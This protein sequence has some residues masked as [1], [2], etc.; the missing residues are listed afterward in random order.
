[1]IQKVLGGLPNQVQMAIAQTGKRCLAPMPYESDLEYL[2]E[3][4]H[5]G[6]NRLRIRKLELE[7]PTRFR[8][9]DGKDP[10][11]L[12]SEYRQKDKTLETR[13][14]RRLEAS[15]T[16]NNW[17][18]RIDTLAE[19][20]GLDEFE[21]TVLLTLVG[22]NVSIEMQKAG[23]HSVG[24][25]EIGDILVLWCDSFDQMVQ[26]RKYFRKSATLVKEGMVQLWDNS[27]INFMRLEIEIDPRLLDYLVGLDVNA[28]DL[29][30]GSHFYTPAVKLDQVIL[31]TTGIRGFFETTG[32]CQLFIPA[33][34]D[35]MISGA[36]AR[37]AVYEPMLDGHYSSPHISGWLLKTLR[38]I[39]EILS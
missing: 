5:F 23:D 27:R 18:P 25:P 3:W 26:C 14:A 30:E 11:Q 12:L 38:D 17:K 13:L 37:L 33:I 22:A 31:A 10:E 35:I 1:M 34:C 6:A 29:V 8:E 19:L 9:R 4:F 28:A 21:K 7:D 16:T 32:T 2:E 36:S 24:H 39:R 20:R 15:K